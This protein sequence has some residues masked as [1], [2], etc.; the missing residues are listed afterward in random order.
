MAVIDAA[1]G[2][3]VDP[4][5][6]IVIGPRGNPIGWTTPEGYIVVRSYRGR[7]A[8]ALAHRL[9]WEAVNGPIP[10]DKQINHINGVKI[11]NRIE[12]LEVVTPHENVLHA[13]RTGLASNRGENGPR[14]I[15]TQTQVDE[16][17]S[18]YVRGARG[19]AS[20]RA[21]AE[22]LGVSRKAVHDAIIGRSWGFPKRVALADIPIPTWE[23]DRKEAA[24]ERLVDMVDIDEDEAPD[25]NPEGDPTLNGAYR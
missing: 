11:D 15:L 20:P 24:I 12:N 18:H 6:G 19:D 2:L 1:L 9:I 8:D 23:A 25:R 10:A 22:A 21:L 7:R 4:E 17:R 16:L 14:H 13:Y 5:R 3:R